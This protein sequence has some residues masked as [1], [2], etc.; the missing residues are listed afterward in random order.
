MIAG[1]P[2][3]S[4]LAE[5]GARQLIEL[6]H[7]IDQIRILDRLEID[8]R[9]NEYG[10]R[11]VRMIADVGRSCVV[12]SHA[13]DD[14]IFAVSLDESLDHFVTLLELGHLDVVAAIVTRIICRLHMHEA[15]VV[16]TTFERFSCL[17]SLT[18]EIRVVV[19]GRT[20]DLY[21]RNLK[22]YADAA[23]DGSRRNDERSQ[24]M[25]LQER[26][27][28]QPLAAAPKREHVRVRQSLL[29]PFNIQWMLPQHSPNLVAQGLNQFC[30]EF[31]L[32]IARPC[33]RD[34]RQRPLVDKRILTTNMIGHAWAC[35]LQ[36]AS[37]LCCILTS[38]FVLRIS[39]NAHAVKNLC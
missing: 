9:A 15:K 26:R 38:D 23:N 12:S 21:E 17:E 35:D 20:L 14:I 39:R 28:V 24:F 5:L 6:L 2:P 19:A 29:L 30:G 36:S 27:H 33:A 31:C 18:I 3:E 25:L 11:L 1:E 13:D 37:V 8:K 4:G 16:F 22:G 32:F 10:H 7:L 34:L